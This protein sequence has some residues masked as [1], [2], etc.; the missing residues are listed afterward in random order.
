[1]TNMGTPVGARPAG[2][3]MDAATLSLLSGRHSLFL[4]ITPEAALLPDA[5]PASLLPD[6]PAPLPPAE[7]ATLPPEPALALPDTVARPLV[8]ET[9]LPLPPLKFAPPDEPPANEEPV[10]LHPAAMKDA[11]ARIA[12]TTDAAASVIVARFRP[13]AEDVVVSR[14][15]VHVGLCARERALDSCKR[16]P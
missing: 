9:P 11:M 6:A 15:P 12:R 16:N 13:S 5:L 3:L 4:P 14:P 7:L 2:G 10:L 8:E 1:M